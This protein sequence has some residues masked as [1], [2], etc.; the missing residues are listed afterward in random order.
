MS[1]DAQEEKS[2]PQRHALVPGVLPHP[3]VHRAVRAATLLARQ[4]VPAPVLRGNRIADAQGLLQSLLG[5]L[6]LALVDV[7]LPQTAVAFPDPA[8][9]VKVSRSHVSSAAFSK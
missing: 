8:N 4:R 2:A 9:R 7:G 6:I 5:F 3:L 1:Q